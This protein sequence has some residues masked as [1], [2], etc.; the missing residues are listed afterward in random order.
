MPDTPP[1]DL[2]Y[3]DP[4]EVDDWIRRQLHWGPRV[5]D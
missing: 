5:V 3:L 4:A 2:R 1:H